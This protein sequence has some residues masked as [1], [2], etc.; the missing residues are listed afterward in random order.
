MYYRLKEEYEDKDVDLL[1]IWSA[2]LLWQHFF[3]KGFWM[4]L[5]SV[6]IVL[7]IPFIT[8]IISKKVMRISMWIIVALLYLSL[9]AYP[10]LEL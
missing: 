6:I 2:G 8:E 10:F 9:L 5:L 4:T 1:T 7:I 3:V